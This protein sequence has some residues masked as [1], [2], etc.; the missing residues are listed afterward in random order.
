M[1]PHFFQRLRRK[2]KDT[3]TDP[4]STALSHI[5][6]DYDTCRADGSLRDSSSMP[7]PPPRRPLTPPPDSSSST[8]DLLHVDPQSESLFFTR[9]SPS[10][11]NRIYTELLGDRSVHLEYDYGYAPGYRQRDKRPPDQWRWWHR[12]CDEDDSQPGDLCRGVDLED[13]KRVGRKEL[14]KH[15]LK[16]VHW[17]RTCRLGYQEALPVLYASNT[18]LIS[19]SVKLCRLPKLIVPSHLSA[20]TSLNLLHITKT[21]TPSTMTDETWATYNTIFRTLRLAYIGLHRLRLTIHILNK[22]C[23]PRAGT[24]PEELEEAW[25]RPWHELA[26]SR[27]WEKLEIGIQ[28]S[29]FE[30]FAGAARRYEKRH[31]RSDDAGYSLVQVEDFTTWDGKLSEVWNADYL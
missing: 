3:S 16:G 23:T 4:R 10:I 2:P 29:W 27:P 18:F 21:N 31:G 22:S 26:S 5:G 28:A 12:V 9:L 6:V 14:D 11:R 15:K 17:L 8:S 13:R 24:V 19:S 30:D 7:I 1:A 25:F 20:I